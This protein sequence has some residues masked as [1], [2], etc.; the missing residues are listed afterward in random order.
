[1]TDAE[2]LAV[3]PLRSLISKWKEDSGA[4]YRTWFRWEERLKNFRFIRRGLGQVVAEINA[5]TF[6]NVY[7]GSSLETVV[8]AIAEQRQMFSPHI[9]SFRWN[10][11]HSPG[12]QQPCLL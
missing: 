6:R 2:I 4:T 5:G 10:M 8:R 7:K 3:D 12:A 9:S 1:M 11:F